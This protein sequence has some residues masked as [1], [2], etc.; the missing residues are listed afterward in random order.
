MKKTLEE[1]IEFYEKKAGVKYK[2]PDKRTT[3]FYFPDK[4]FAEIGV[5]KDIVIVHQLCGDAHF[6]KQVAEVLATEHGI[7]YLGTWCIRNIKPY[8]RYFG[9]K[10]ESTEDLG[11]GLTRYHG[12]FK[13]TGKI[14]TFTPKFE[15]KNGN[16]GYLVTWEI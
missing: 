15:A 5:S 2:A 7:H 1:W 16:I 10:I 6:W 11:K 4:G 12:K 3:R 13:D 8:I 9:V 14:A